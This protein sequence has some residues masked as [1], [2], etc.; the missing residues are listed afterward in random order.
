VGKGITFDSGGL[1]LKGPSHME[2][3]KGDM[4]GAAV[5]LATVVAAGRLGLAGGVTGYLAAAENMPGGRAQRPG[6]VITTRD[7]TTVEVLNTD[8]EGRLV[9]A[10]GLAAARE[11][12]PDALVDIATLTG[13]K[14]TALGESIAAV[15][16][17]AAIRQAVLDA[18]AAAGEAIWPLPLPG[19]YNSMLET[20]IADIKNVSGG[21]AASPITAGL[22]LKRFAG[23]AAWAHIDVAGQEINSRE[24]AGSTP[25]GATGFGVR[26]LIA[27][28]QARAAA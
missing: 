24:A 8:A 5:V 4:G 19:A 10:D 16:G 3:M 28:C 15:M 21:P 17:V 14:V 1:S 2:T 20:P 22:F 13:G 25:K 6:D 26:S 23:D 11:G 9:L 7:G 12:K 27:F 18:A